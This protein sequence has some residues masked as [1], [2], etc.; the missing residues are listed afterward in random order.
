ME[1]LFRRKASTERA[2][3]CLLIVG[4]FGLGVAAPAGAVVTD[5]DFDAKASMAEA[6]PSAKIERSAL[7]P[8]RQAETKLPADQSVGTCADDQPGECG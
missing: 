4:L 7:F 3:A 1:M 2:L 6:L 5:L 8:E